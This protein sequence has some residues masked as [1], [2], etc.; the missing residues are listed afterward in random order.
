MNDPKKLPKIRH[1]RTVA[2]LCQAIS[3]QMRHISTI[4]KPC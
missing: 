2:Q 3:S 4:G 1:L